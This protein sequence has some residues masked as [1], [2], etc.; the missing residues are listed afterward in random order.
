MSI[1][2]K[3]LVVPSTV[4]L[5]LLAVIGTA[6]AQQTRKIDIVPGKQVAALAQ[7]QGNVEPELSADAQS[8]VPPAD[9]GQ[10]QVGQQAGLDPRDANAQAETAPSLSGP[11]PQGSDTKVWVSETDKRLNRQRYIERYEA[12]QQYEE[13]RYVGHHYAAPRYEQR[14]AQPRYVEQRYVAPRYEAPRQAYAQHY[15][16][17]PSYGYVKRTAEH[18]APRR[19]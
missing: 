3:S 12:R 14:Y 1:F 4:A 10:V 19:Y 6:Q 18:C 11:S 9:A 5:S 17:A 7:P 8:D 13:P 15:Q 2:A 16:A